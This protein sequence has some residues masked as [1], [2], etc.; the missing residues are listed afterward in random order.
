M[1]SCRSVFL[2]NLYSV[3]TRP[4]PVRCGKWPGSVSAGPGCALESPIWGDVV[5]YPGCRLSM[6]AGAKT[7]P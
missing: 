3:M 5:K 1:E 4:D 7:P 6:V 2:A